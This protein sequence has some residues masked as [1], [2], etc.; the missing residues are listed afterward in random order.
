MEDI[1]QVYHQL[2][3]QALL[4]ELTSQ[5]NLPSRRLLEF[6]P[7]L[8][9]QPVP[10]QVVDSMRWRGVGIYKE[11]TRLHRHGHRQ[12]DRLQ[13]RGKPSQPSNCRAGLPRHRQR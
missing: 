1:H 10:A 12:A 4:P 13:L 5:R 9:K 3:T 11:A 2:Q 8:S 7:L 6:I